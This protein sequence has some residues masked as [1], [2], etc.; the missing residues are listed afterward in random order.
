MPKLAI[1]GAPPLR[2]KPFPSYRTI[3][4]EEKRAVLEVLDSGVLS[5]F[6]GT[7]SPQFY[8]G[9]RVRKLEAEWAKYFGVKHAISVNSASSALYAAA[10]AAGV[11]P[12]DEV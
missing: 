9:S 10:G 1:N 5:D 12:G 4:A 6:L 8:G 11:G 3:G 2:R 7:W